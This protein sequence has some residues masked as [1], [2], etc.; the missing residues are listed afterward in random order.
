[1]SVSDGFERREKKGCVVGLEKEK[2]A[3]MGLIH[4]NKKEV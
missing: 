1:L 3:K 2:K 4:L